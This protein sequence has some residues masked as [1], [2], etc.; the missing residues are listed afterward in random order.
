MLEAEIVQSINNYLVHKGVRFSNESRM[1]IGIP[2]VSF[3]IGANNRL[4]PINDYFMLSIL[5]FI[6]KKQVVSFMEIKNEYL[7]SFDK[8][9]QYL[10]ALEKLSLVKINN[11]F[12]QVIKNVFLAKLGTTF[13]VEAKIKNWKVAYLQAQRYLCFS[14]YSYIALSDKYIHN[15]NSDLFKESGIGILSISK[16]KVEEVLAAKK[17]KTC[18]LILKYIITSKIVEYRTTSEKK[19]LKKNIFTSYTI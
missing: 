7:L 15:V 19:R 17:S 10:N 16:D 8:V 5:E 9:K 1:G 2:D 14:D 13:S 3:N 18:E 6:G 11:K 12:V 4:T